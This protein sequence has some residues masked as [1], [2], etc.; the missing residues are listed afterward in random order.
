MFKFVLLI[1]RTSGSDIGWQ[2]IVLTTRGD[3]KAVAR[4]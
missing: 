1:R 3:S 4:P 2:E